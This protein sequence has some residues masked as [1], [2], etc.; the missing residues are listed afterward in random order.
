[1]YVP[2]IIVSAC[3]YIVIFL[4]SLLLNAPLF[5]IHTYHLTDENVAV[6]RIDHQRGPLGDHDAD[7]QARGHIDNNGTSHFYCLG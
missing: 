4:S 6:E 5:D 1:M 2:S 3:Q 7:Q